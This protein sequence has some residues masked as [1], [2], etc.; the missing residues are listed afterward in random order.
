MAS[1]QTSE[2]REAVLWL[3]QLQKPIRTQSDPVL[4]KYEF[5]LHA[6]VSQGMLGISYNGL[7]CQWVGE[8]RHSEKGGQLG[9]FN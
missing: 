7:L 1:E 9:D 4:N 5:D 6:E 2:L 8:G 3:L